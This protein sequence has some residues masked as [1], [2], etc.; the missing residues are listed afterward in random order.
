MVSH[1][2]LTTLALSA[3]MG[4]RGAGE[5]TRFQAARGREGRPSAGQERWHIFPH[6]QPEKCLHCPLRDHWAK[7]HQAGSPE[8]ER[9]EPWESVELA[10]PGGFSPHPIFNFCRASAMGWYVNVINK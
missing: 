1:A 8:L 3:P 6:A 2:T 4:A 9:N 7:I 5:H 10:G